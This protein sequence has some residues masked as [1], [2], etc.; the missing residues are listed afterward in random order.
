MGR[1]A[2]ARRLA[3]AAAY[4]GGGLVAP[5]RARSTGVL[6]AEAKLARRAIGNA[7]GRVPDS[8]GWYGRGRP[9]PGHQDR[10]A[11]GLQRGRVRRRTAS[12]R[13]PGPGSA[14]ASPSAR[15]DGCTCA[16]SR[17]WAPS[18]AT[19]RPRSTAALPV[20]PDVAVILI[21]ANDV[22]H[23][24]LP[25]GVGALPLRGRTPPAEADVAVV[26]G[27]CP[28]LG[29]ISP[30]PAPLRQ[31]ARVVVAPAGRRPDDRRR[32]GRRPHGVARLDPGPGVRGGT[33]AAV[34]ARPLPPLR[35]RLRG[36]GPRC[37][38]PRCS[39]PSA[40]ARRRRRRHASVAARRCCRSAT[41]PSRPA[42]TPAPR[43]TAPRSAAPSAASAAAG[44]R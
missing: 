18:P 15:T 20:D 12:S 13:R 21:G 5:R 32:R 39:R 33:G 16:S 38:S 26:V 23:T 31:V 44:S 4:G 43:S 6:R 42:R 30:L 37:S 28:D 40:W 8:T 1:A 27:T 29:T 19:S 10:A 2:A 7:D 35:R 34:R 25:V 9:G 41:P 36:A 24:V 17:S 14:R 11:R 3:A 22:T